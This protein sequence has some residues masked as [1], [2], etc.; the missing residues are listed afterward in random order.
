MP[1]RQRCQRKASLALN[2][3]ARSYYPAVSYQPPYDWSAWDFNSA[4]ESDHPPSSV[5]VAV[6]F[7]LAGAAIEALAMILAMLAL[8]RILHEAVYVQIGPSPLH[9]SVDIGLAYLLVLGLIRTGLWL[10]MAANNNAGRRW[11]RRLSTAFFGI[12]SLALAY[13]IV[14]G[15]HVGGAQLLFTVALWFVGIAAIILLWQRESSE[16]I[17]ARARRY[18]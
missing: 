8:G 12:Y 11:A 2:R 10:W 16:F 14:R 17:A 3:G 5:R 9:W 15:V 4:L 18:Y 13:V 1:K 6:R 7:I